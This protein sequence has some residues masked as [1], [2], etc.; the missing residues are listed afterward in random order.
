MR[1]R[2]KEIAK[3]RHA[4]IM[5]Q[6]GMRERNRDRKK[7]SETQK[8]RQTDENTVHKKEPVSVSPEQ[9]CSFINAPP[10]RCFNRGH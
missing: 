2:E 3:E 1:Q 7:K 9:R 4:S 8:D 6:T 10:S 5:S